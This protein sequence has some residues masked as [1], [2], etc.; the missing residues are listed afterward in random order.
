MGRSSGP[1]PHRAG[2]SIRQPYAGLTSEGFSGEDQKKLRELFAQWSRSRILCVTRVLPTGADRINEALHRRALRE[3][4]FSL[5]GSVDLIPGEP[6]MMQVNDYHRMLFNGDQGVIL[7]VSDEGVAP[8]RM[9]VFA[10]S[11]AFVAFP[12]ESTPAGLG[13]L[14]RHDRSQGAGL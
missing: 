5:T 13:A 4:E 10:R 2:V 11:N 9:A 7:N 14:L 1:H 6:V 3:G 8:Q 12:V